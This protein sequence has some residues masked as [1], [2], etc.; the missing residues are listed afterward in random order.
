MAEPLRHLDG[1]IMMR[2]AADA[3]ARQNRTYALNS[4]ARG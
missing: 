1:T 2:L 4:S 3:L